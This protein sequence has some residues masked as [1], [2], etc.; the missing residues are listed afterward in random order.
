MKPRAIIFGD[1]DKKNAAEAVK[2]FRSF[3]TD[4][5]NIVF[6]SFDGSRID[7]LLPEADIAFTF[8]GDGTLL[9]AA[10][11]LSSLG[12]PVVG[13]NAGRLGFL[14]EFSIEEI[15]TFFDAVL[16]RKLP[17]EKRML[18]QCKVYSDGCEKFDRLAV[19][20]VAVMAGKPFRMIELLIEVEGEFLADPR[21]DGLIISTPTGSTAYNLSAGGPILSSALEAMVITPVSCQSLSFRPVVIPPEYRVCIIPVKINRGTWVTLDGQASCSIKK[22]DYIEVTRAKSTFSVVS[23]PNRTYWSTLS[24]KLHWAKKP[25][26]S[27]TT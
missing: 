7:G 17:I 10:S 11:H 15:K 8:G 3:S 25:R 5:I 9:S 18:L 2:Y 12:I 22:H 1:P 6:D 13:V 16:E 23:N 19:N 20:E 24:D 26:Y 4:R 14:A 21:S 27:E